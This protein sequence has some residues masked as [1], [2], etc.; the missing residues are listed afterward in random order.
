ME[1]IR[2]HR[3]QREIQA[4]IDFTP[5]MNLMIAL[6]PVLLMSIV[7]AHTTVIDLDFPASGGGVEDVQ[8]LHLEII[9][10][11]DALVVADGTGGVIKSLP[12]TGG[13]HDFEQLALVMQEMKKRVP[14]KREVTILLEPGTDYQTLV[15]VMDRV[16]S[17]HRMMVTK[18]VE[19]ELFPMISLGDAPIRG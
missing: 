9:V 15:S 12:A 5:F 19:A 7:F 18:F 14:D 6:T 1:R 11:A 8:D 2:R 4:E 17:H 13:H 10:R 3:A 16:R